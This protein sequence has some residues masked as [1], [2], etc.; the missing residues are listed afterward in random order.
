MVATPPLLSPSCTSFA[1]ESLEKN[2]ASLT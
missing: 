2:I 1:P